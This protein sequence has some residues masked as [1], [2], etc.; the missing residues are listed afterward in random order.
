M[1]LSCRRRVYGTRLE[2]SPHR[3]QDRK[4][5]SLELIINTAVETSLQQVSLRI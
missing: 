5:R 1:L 3:V 4:D 2:T